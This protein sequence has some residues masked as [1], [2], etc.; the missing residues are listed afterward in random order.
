MRTHPQIAEQFIIALVQNSTILHADVGPLC[1]MQNAI[2]STE[3]SCARASRIRL[4]KIQKPPSSSQFCNSASALPCSAQYR[5]GILRS[6]AKPRKTHTVTG[7]LPSPQPPAPSP[8]C[9][10]VPPHP[11]TYHR[12]VYGQT[13]RRTSR[14][15]T[16]SAQD[17]P[18]PAFRLRAPRSL[19]FTL[20]SVL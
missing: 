1:T 19:L 18:S 6:T 3:T 8:T 7:F 13:A 20:T 9:A 11:T 14:Q 2:G 15:T 10:L 5:W 17:S 12:K 16:V 4:C